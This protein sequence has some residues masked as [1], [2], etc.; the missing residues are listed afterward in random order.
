VGKFIAF[1]GIDRAGKSTVLSYV[2]NYLEQ[3][4]IS[5]VSTATKCIAGNRVPSMKGYYPDEIVYM[6][7]W[8]AIR[9]AELTKIRPALEEGKIVFC[10][11]YMLSNLAI[12]WWE[13]L[14]SDFKKIMDE[15]Y[16]DRCQRPDLTLVFTIPYDVFVSRD[17]GASVLSRTQ[18]ETIQQSYIWWGQQLLGEGMCIVFV[19][20][21]QLEETVQQQVLGSVLEILGLGA[22]VV[23]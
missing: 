5:V 13:D 2:K 15:V 16:L 12:E 23:V 11:R 20:G 17:D 7:F 6:F 22:E 19:D 9:N 4:G 18:F 1:E 8:Q 21:S 14:D 3:K 10:D